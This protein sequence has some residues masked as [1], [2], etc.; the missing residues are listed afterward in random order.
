MQIKLPRKQWEKLSGGGDPAE[1][2]R[3]VVNLAAVTKALGTVEPAAAPAKPV[4][5][6][7]DDKVQLLRSKTLSAMME[8]G[9]EEDWGDV[10]EH[11]EQL[12]MLIERARTHAK[13]GGVHPDNDWA[14]LGWE[15][16]ARDAGISI[17]ASSPK[18]WSA[19]AAR[20][21]PYGGLL[22]RLLRPRW[23]PSRRATGCDGAACAAS[24][25]GPPWARWRTRG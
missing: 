2:L 11:G 9:G 24:S 21:G 12:D 23:Q 1:L 20:R 18:T 25:S 6:Y 5:R 14:T 10:T 4:D 3:K 15:D 16:W 19:P 22:T 7:G 17:E 8:R 13:D